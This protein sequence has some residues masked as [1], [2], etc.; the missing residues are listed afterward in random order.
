[1]IIGFLQ[2]QLCVRGSSVAMYDY[3]DFSETI[4]KNTSVILLPKSG[5][6]R[7]DPIGLKKFQDRFK[8]II[9]PDSELEETLEKVGVKILYVI[10]Y[11]KK[12]VLVSNRVKTVIHCVF[13][14]SEPHGDVYAGVSEEVAVKYG[15]IVF[16]PHMIALKPELKSVPDLRKDLG[17]PETAIVFGRYG[18]MDTFNLDFVWEVIAM[19]LTDRKDVHFLFVNTPKGLI[20]PRVHYREKIVTN[21][22]KQIFISACDAHLEC[23]T[24][25]HS[26]GLA[27]GEFSVMNKPIVAYKPKNPQGFW[28]DAHLK[29]LGDKG[30]YYSD[31]LDFYRILMGFCREDYVG[32]DLNCYKEYSPEKVMNIFQRVFIDS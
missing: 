16:V 22:E 28:N 4:L 26:F 20:H 15:K 17:I 11:G 21:T 19:V 5:L 2:E 6:H 7:S 1:M 25:G 30:V 23:G 3:A 31:A 12:D 32:K 8:V 18:G 29:I 14:M 24:M 10:K 9:Y 27:I 13:D